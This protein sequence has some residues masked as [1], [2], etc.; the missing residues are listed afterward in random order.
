M[1]TN[2]F[3]F[4]SFGVIRAIQICFSDKGSCKLQERKKRSLKFARPVDFP[5]DPDHIRNCHPELVSG[6]MGY[7]MLKSYKSFSMTWRLEGS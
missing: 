4:A 2:A 1:E 3:F 6:S 7:P 5:Y